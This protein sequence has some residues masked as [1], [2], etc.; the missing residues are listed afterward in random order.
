MIEEIRIEIQKLKTGREDLK[1]FGLTMAVV[2]GLLSALTWYKG[3]ASC[4]YLLGLALAFLGVGL[5]APMLLKQIYRYWMTLAVILGS[6]M[7]KVIL[8]LLF[9]TAI[10]GIGFLSGLSNKDR[11]NQKFDPQAESYWIPYKK[12]ADMKRHLERQF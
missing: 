10:T 3:S 11:L 7:T 9:Y 1:K 6:I 12:P 8:S 2:L 5:I 4:P